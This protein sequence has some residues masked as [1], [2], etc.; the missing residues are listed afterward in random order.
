MR[1]VALTSR[2]ST[3]DQNMP[4]SSLLSGIALSKSHSARQ[5]NHCAT[6]ARLLCRRRA[7]ACAGV[8]RQGVETLL[9][10][11]EARSQGQVSMPSLLVQL[12]FSV[13]L[14]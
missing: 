12:A 3:V 7:L 6:L 2:R 1:L 13:R 14:P 10:S 4:K 8:A 11:I 5:L 9:A